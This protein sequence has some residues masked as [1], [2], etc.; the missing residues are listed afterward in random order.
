MEH[1]IIQPEA[2]GVLLG[3]LLSL[4]ALKTTWAINRH[5]I[6]QPGGL[7]F[8]APPQRVKFL[9]VPQGW[10]THRPY[11]NLSDQREQE[12]RISRNT[13]IWIF[14]AHAEIVRTGRAIGRFKRVDPTPTKHAARRQTPAP[15][16]GRIWTC[17][18]DP[19]ILS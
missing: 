15:N 8:G 4:S 16:R 14:P 11:H 19:S 13:G 5:T 17:V 2:I 3:L 1:L 12:I 9:G 7:P 10:F 6:S 18:T